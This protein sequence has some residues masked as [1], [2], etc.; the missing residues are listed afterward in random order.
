M[1]K[2]NKSTAAK[3]VRFPSGLRD[4]DEENNVD[5]NINAETG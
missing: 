5:A 1:V 2:Q 3:R 4:R